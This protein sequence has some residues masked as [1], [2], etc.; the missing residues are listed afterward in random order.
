MQ[1]RLRCFFCGL[2][3]CLWLLFPAGCTGGTAAP[4][5]ANMEFEET[6]VTLCQ[7]NFRLKGALTFTGVDDVVLRAEE[8]A[9]LA[10]VVF[11]WYGGAYTVEREEVSVAPAE[12]DGCVRLFLQAVRAFAVGE[13]AWEGDGWHMENIVLQTDARGTPLE[14]RDKATGWT[15][16]FGEDCPGS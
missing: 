10:G 12:N 8:P 2:L 9:A 15:A 16:I 11:R 7:G 13:A 3:A 4:A 6:P 14:M 5:P 1:M